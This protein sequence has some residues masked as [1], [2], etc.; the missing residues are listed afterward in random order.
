M[1]AFRLP[2]GAPIPSAPPWNRHRPFGCVDE[3]LHGVHAGECAP[4]IRRPISFS[5]DSTF[6]HH[7]RVH[8]GLIGVPRVVVSASATDQALFLSTDKHR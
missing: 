5:T 7:D 2:F 1:S 3:S 6:A 4:Q 8:C